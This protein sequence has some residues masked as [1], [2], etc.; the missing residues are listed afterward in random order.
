MFGVRCIPSGDVC[1]G[2]MCGSTTHSDELLVRRANA[3]ELGA[4]EVLYRRH[5]DWAV[6]VAARCGC[7][8]DDALDVVQDAFL[9]LLRQFPGFE[10]RAKMRTVLYPIIRNGALARRRKRQTQNSHRA[11]FAVSR[12]VDANDASVDSDRDA[13]L[14]DLTRMLDAMPEFHREVLY[15]RFVDDFDI[16]EI[17]TVLEIPAGTVKSRLHHALAALRESDTAKKWFF[18]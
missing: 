7:G 4:F 3:G 6:R 1:C 13:L 11:T 18:Q 8:H 12:T 14:H 10:L 2:A 9:W 16:S 15:L 5:R 17:A